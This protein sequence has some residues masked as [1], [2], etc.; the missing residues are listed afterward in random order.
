MAKRKYIAG[1]DGH[2]HEV[3]TEDQRNE[4]YLKHYG[5]RADAPM[6]MP[7]LPEFVSPIDGRT[8]SGRAGMREHC[9]LHDVVPTRELAGLPPKYSA[10]APTVDRAGIRSELIKQ[11]YK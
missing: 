2:W 8:Y 7:D 3:T 6:V 11:I 5:S 4:F 9:R 1:P 10:T